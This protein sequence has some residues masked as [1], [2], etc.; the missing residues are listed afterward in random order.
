MTEHIVTVATTR[1][2]LD[3][4]RRHL[5]NQFLGHTKDQI[6]V[7]ELLR[8]VEAVTP[9]SQTSRVI[10]PARSIPPVPSRTSEPPVQ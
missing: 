8:D 7:R 2:R 1:E 5:M 9:T 10:E 3:A 4:L 6:L